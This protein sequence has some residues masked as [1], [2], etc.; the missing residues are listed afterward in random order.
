MALFGAVGQVIAYSGYQPGFAQ[1]DPAL[2]IPLA[3]ANGVVEMSGDLYPLF[4]PFLGWIGTFLTGYGTASIVLFGKLQVDT[5]EILKISP[6][7]LA[8]GMAVGSAIGSISSPLKIAL[9]APLCGAQGREGE[10]LQR[11]IPLGL[12]ICLLLG[13]LLL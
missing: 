9:A 4:A 2:N 10:I 8:S 1:V 7:L 11:T 6:V 3:L 5:A 13:V 12:G